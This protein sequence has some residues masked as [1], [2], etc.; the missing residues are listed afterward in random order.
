MAHSYRN[1]AVWN[2]RLDVAALR[3]F[4]PPMG[5]E[6]LVADQGEAK[7]AASSASKA[8]ISWLCHG[9]STRIGNELLR[10]D[11]D[12]RGL[13]SLASCHDFGAGNDRQNDRVKVVRKG[14]GTSV[15]LCRLGKQLLIGR[16]QDVLDHEFSKRF[17]I[18]VFVLLV[19]HNGAFPVL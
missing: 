11:E 17:E 6:C 1:V 10:P 18:G 8:L 3:L 13:R 19:F 14:C 15:I 16:T 5:I 12:R 7:D 2:D 9:N 4:A